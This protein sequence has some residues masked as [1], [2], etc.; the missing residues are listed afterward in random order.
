L[1][2]PS[3]VAAA[4]HKFWTHSVNARGFLSNETIYNNMVVVARLVVLILYYSH[5]P[6]FVIRNW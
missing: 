1:L 2:I 4:I 6:D 5:V 3:P